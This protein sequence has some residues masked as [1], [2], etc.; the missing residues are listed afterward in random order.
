MV[1]NP[2]IYTECKHLTFSKPCAVQT[3]KNGVKDR[4]IKRECEKESSN[5]RLQGS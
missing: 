2:I 1:I 5:R 3:L 4:E